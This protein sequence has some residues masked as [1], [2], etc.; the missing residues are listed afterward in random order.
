MLDHEFLNVDLEIRQPRRKTCICSYDRMSKIWL[1][2]K[3]HFQNVFKHSYNIAFLW[4]ITLTNVDST[5]LASVLNIKIMTW[6]TRQ[7]SSYVKENK[8]QD[9]VEVD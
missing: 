3:G 9:S 2:H 5:W 1:V 7:V 4:L 6:L 8:P